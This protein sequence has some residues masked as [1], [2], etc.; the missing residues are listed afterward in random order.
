[1]PKLSKRNI[2]INRKT[3]PELFW[4]KIFIYYIN[5]FGGFDYEAKS[6]STTTIDAKGKSR[7]GEYPEL[8]MQLTWVKEFEFDPNKPV[9]KY[10]HFFKE[11]I[12]EAIGRKTDKYTKGK[13][14][15]DVSD[16]ILL[17]QGY[18]SRVW[19]NDILTSKFCNQYKSNPFRGIYYLVRPTIDLKG[20]EHPKNGEVLSIK[21]CFNFKKIKL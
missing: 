16:I 20:K 12:E 1:M 21:P 6:Y 7:S 4:A 19:A 8:N 17:L 15:W 18:M 10:L 13:K 14:K 9:T 11:N 2:L 5:R 3:E